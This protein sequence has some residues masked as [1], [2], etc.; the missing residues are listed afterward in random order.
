MEHATIRARLSAQPGASP[1]LTRHG[2]GLSHTPPMVDT[3]V[4][5]GMHDNLDDPLPEFEEYT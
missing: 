5:V 3:V 1:A 4:S 2:H